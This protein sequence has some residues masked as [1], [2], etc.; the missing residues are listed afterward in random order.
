M[1]GEF[2]ESSMARQTETIY[3][4]EYLQL[5]TILATARKEWIHQT[6]PYSILACTIEIENN[7]KVAL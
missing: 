1:F 2:G 3:T 5:I 4:T 6:F 7:V